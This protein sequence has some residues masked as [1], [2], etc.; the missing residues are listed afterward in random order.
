M[1]SINRDALI[2][3]ARAARDQAYAP[4]SKFHVGAAV[5]TAD[6]TIIPGCNIENAAYPSTMCAERVALHNAYAHGARE[7]LALA[8]IADTPGPVSPCGG[9][10]QVMS[11]LCPGAVIFLANTAGAWVQT[12][13][14]ALLPGAFDPNDLPA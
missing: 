8:V 7:I 12:S 3:A 6:G 5:L 1:T 2:A 13:L 14:P 10:R 11:E 9:C 4:Y